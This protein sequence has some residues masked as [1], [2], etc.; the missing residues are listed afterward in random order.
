MTK[1]KLVTI[2]VSAAVAVVLLASLIIG[3]II[4]N[5]REKTAKTIMTCSVNPQVQ[6]VLN[7]KNEVMKVVA[8]N[9]DGQAIAMEVDFVG[10]DAE[11]AAEMFVKI[12]T[13]AGYIDVNTSGTSVKFDLN[14]QKKNYDKLKNKI[15]E[16]VN[17]FFDENGIIAGA[18]TTI[19][20]DFKKAVK[21]LKPN[22]LNL[23]DKS[24]KD[25]MD[26]YMQICDMINGMEPDRLT[27]FYT[28]YND[29]Y[30][31][32]LASQTDFEEQI[33]EQEANLQEYKAEIDGMPDGIE[34]T[35]LQESI[36]I[37]ET[38]IKYLKT[39]LYTL[40][41]NYANNRDY[42]IDTIKKQ[43]ESVFETI[44]TEINKNIATFEGKLAE[45]K[46]YYENNKESVNAAIAEFRQSLNA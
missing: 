12:S 6:F 4:N 41:N 20:E 34:K 28:K 15:N 13:K 35:A 3:L 22:A 33:A 18:I 46:T 1:K 36:R 8:L 19:T 37:A 27:E 32:F 9:N 44:K 10:L 16:K 11:D 42:L 14:G 7:D 17:A 30:N 29:A 5:N 40:Q 21:A 43:S 24:K 31:K 26:H 39:D 45:R 25:L 38:A 23:D 2:I